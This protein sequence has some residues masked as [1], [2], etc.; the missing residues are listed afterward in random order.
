MVLDVSHEEAIEKKPV[1]REAVILNVP[2]YERDIYEYLRE[3][4]V[5]YFPYKWDKFVYGSIS[6]KWKK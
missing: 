5:C 3:A 4:E 1:D 6:G 2:E